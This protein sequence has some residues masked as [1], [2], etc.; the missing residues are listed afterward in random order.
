MTLRHPIAYPPPAVIPTS[1]TVAVPSLTDGRAERPHGLEPTSATAMWA[2]TPFERV[3]GGCSRNRFAVAR[4][5]H[6]PSAPDHARP[7]RALGTRLEL[8]GR[9]CT[10]L[11]PRRSTPALPPP[12]RTIVT[13]PSDRGVTVNATSRPARR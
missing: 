1:L 10:D 7:Q 3:L 11:G 9:G 8:P 2:A 5:G 6:P 4:P 12:V 13:V